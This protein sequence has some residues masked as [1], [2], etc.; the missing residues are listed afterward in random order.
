MDKLPISRAISIKLAGFNEEW[1]QTQIWENPSQIGLGDLET[2]TRETAVSSGGRLDILLKNP[3]SD[4]MYEVE[5]MLGETDP[6]HIIRTIEYWDLIRR[7]WPQRQH[8]GVLIAEKISKRYFNVIQILSNNVPLVAI[9]VNIIELE[10]RRSLHF[11]KIID[12]YEEP[13]DDLVGIAEQIDESFWENKS[14]SV[15]NTAKKIFDL[16]KVIYEDT[17]LGYNKTNITINSGG[18]NQMYFKKRYEGLVLI[19]F[20]FGSRLSEIEELLQKN[21]ISF[22]VDTKRFTIQLYERQIE[23]KSDV[24]LEIA[25]FNKR[26]WQD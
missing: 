6:S 2:V 10:D 9:Q 5:V 25:K 26:W 13:E 19:A 3:E 16:T 17:R 21:E 12:S 1:L 14:N 18:Y 22:N 11:T 7:K 20:I 23:E 15:L 4:T 8:F 24:F